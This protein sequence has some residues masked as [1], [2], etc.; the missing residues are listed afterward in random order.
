MKF[1]INAKK[2]KIFIIKV[3]SIIKETRKKKF[4]D[5]SID[6]VTSKKFEA[7]NLRDA[8]EKANIE[9]KK[10]ELICPQILYQFLVETET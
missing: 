4:N 1:N 2:C 9:W 7:K 10:D 6:Y 5:L 3:M 8:K